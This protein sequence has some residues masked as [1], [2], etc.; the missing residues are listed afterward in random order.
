MFSGLNFNHRASRSETT[1]LINLHKT[2][3]QKTLTGNLLTKYKDGPMSEQLTNE[4]SSIENKTA[5]NTRSI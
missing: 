1:H 4:V 2:H 3:F 5:S